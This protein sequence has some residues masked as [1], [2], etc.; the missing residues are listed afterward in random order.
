MISRNMRNH[1][2][3]MVQHLNRHAKQSATEGSDIDNH[4]LLGRSGNRRDSKTQ[5]ILLTQSNRIFR[6][7]M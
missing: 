6:G 1:D 4:E 2:Y 3:E 7:H 5:Y